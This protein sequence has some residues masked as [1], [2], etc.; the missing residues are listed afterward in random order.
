[1]PSINDVWIFYIEGK[2]NGGW[3]IFFLWSDTFGLGAKMGW[4]EVGRRGWVA[5]SVPHPCSRA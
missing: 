5:I 4:G 2:L 1:M 3:A